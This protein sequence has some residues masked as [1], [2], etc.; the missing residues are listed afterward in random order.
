MQSTIIDGLNIDLLSS[1]KMEQLRQLAVRR[2]SDD[3]YQ[4]VSMLAQSFVAALDNARFNRI[5][6]QKEEINKQ[7]A[8]KKQLE[9]EKK[10]NEQ[11]AS[12]SRSP[13]EGLV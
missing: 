2:Q 10:P 3:L 12:T 9:M 1:D 11:T 13:F 5:E 8:I 6:A 4:P 7:I